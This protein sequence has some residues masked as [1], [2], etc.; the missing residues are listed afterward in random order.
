LN[1]FWRVIRFSRSYLIKYFGHLKYQEYLRFFVYQIHFLR[2][3]LRRPHTDRFPDDALKK[4]RRNR[5][6]DSCEK[7]ATGAE[8]T[9]IR[10]IPAGIGNLVF[11]EACV[12]T[13]SAKFPIAQRLDGIQIIDFGQKY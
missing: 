1:L 3:F 12:L 2:S 5:N 13:S 7:N 8:K 9:G 10:R 6:H 11:H 4:L